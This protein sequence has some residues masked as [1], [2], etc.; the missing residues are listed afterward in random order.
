MTDVQ[1]NDSGSFGER[2]AQEF[3]GEFERSFTV[4]SYDTALDVLTS[5]GEA[6]AVELGDYLGAMESRGFGPAAAKKCL[7]NMGCRVNMDM[8]IDP[9][10]VP[11][12][13]PLNS[14]M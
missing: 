5:R 6:E 9:T 1:Q 7:S 11:S 12:R 3:M 8:H 10:T 4:R 13:D 14:T 2:F